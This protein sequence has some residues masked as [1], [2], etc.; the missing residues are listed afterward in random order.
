M[1]TP[2]MSIIMFATMIFAAGKQ[3]INNKN[4]EKMIT[5]NN[6][7][8]AISYIE[9]G[10]GPKTL[11]FL[12]GWCI[13]KNYWEEQINY[14]S[15]NYKVIALDLPGF[16]KST[17]ERDDW[18]IEQYALDIKAFIDK[19]ELKNVIIVGHSMSGDI[20]LELGIKNPKA[21]I[22]LVGIDNFKLIDVQFTA[23][24][25]AEMN[26][27][28]SM[29]A[30]D[31]KAVAPSFADQMLFH[32]STPKTVKNR[33]KQDIAAASPDIGFS[34]LRNYI[35]YSMG[36]GNKL[37]MLNHK[38]H[39]INSNAT[40]TNIDGLKNNCKQDFVL[41]EINATGHYPM[42]EKPNEFNQ[43]LQFTIQNIN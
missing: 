1:N 11:L 15:Q 41:S 16:G 20:M 2:I 28:V 39:L 32:T 22:G 9:K 24:Q 4:Q 12:H 8:T 10:T 19:L 26:G 13:N 18:T 36:E 42:V 34:S 30:K 33:V 21:I 3:S 5:I 14:F 17:A 27:F 31:F 35:D 6:E 29:L 7:S 23:E 40:P 25:L 43:L 37:K 38:L